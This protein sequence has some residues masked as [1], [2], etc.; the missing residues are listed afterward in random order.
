MSFDLIAIPP[1]AVSNKTIGAIIKGLAINSGKLNVKA[2]TL[3]AIVSN[4]LPYSLVAF[5]FLANLP[6]KASVSPNI[7]EMIVTVVKLPKMAMGTITKG[8][9]I[10]ELV[11]ML[12]IL[13]FILF[14]SQHESHDC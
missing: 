2:K 6:S 9:K 7:T 13:F 8:D 12:G 3:S 4:N 14:F 5:H 10:L 11:K 1:M